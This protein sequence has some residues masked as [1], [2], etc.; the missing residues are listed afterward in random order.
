[1]KKYT[2][3][4]YSN[5]VIMPTSNQ[6]TPKELLKLIETYQ[7]YLKSKGTVPDWADSFLLKTRD[8]FRLAARKHRGQWSVE[9]YE[10]LQEIN[11][12]SIKRG[13]PLATN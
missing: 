9:F 5:M 2:A 3:E 10:T 8:R 4:L 12:E 11:K 6:E 1:M 7:T 13:Q